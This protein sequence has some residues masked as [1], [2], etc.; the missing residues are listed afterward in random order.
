MTALRMTTDLPT[1]QPQGTVYDIG[2]QQYTG[3]RAGRPLARRALFLD[4]IRNALGLGRSGWARYLPWFFI[5][6]PI[7]VGAVFGAIAYFA[8]RTLGEDISEGLDLPSFVE[9]AQANAFFI[10]LFAAV[11]APELTC[12]DRRQNVF[13]LYLVR[14][15][16]V[17]DYLFAKWLGFGLV[18]FG[19]AIL[20]QIALWIG[21][22]LAVPNAAEWF[23]DEW[24]LIPRMVLSSAVIA[25][26]ITA[27]VFLV[28]ALTDRR[29]IASVAI[30]GLMLVTQVVVGITTEL[31]E[32]DGLLWA[33]ATLI[34]LVGLPT[35]TTTQIVFG[36]AFTA[37]EE[38]HF[39]IPLIVTAAMAGGATFGTWFL[40]SRLADD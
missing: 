36:E 32:Q 18:M 4:A 22:L 30:V 7:L 8:N 37:S 1:G 11:M 24:L 3:P 35:V 10:Y 17:T 13:D 21:S 6:P 5:A 34:D 38:M 23:V 9:L 19:V 27:V 28:S 14:P 12:P 2:Y 15:I 29:A 39:S 33:L 40:Y 31:S 20:P 16:T 26:F 25:L